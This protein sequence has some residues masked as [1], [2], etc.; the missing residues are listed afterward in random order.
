LWIAGALGYVMKSVDLIPDGIEDLGYLDDALV[1][2][3]A[4]DRAVKEAGGDDWDIPPQLTRLADDTKVIQQI[5]GSDYVRLDEYV[6]G[7]RILVVRGRSPSDIVQDPSLAL[8]VSQDVASLARAYV[9][10]P[11]AQ[12]GRTLIKLTSFLQAKLP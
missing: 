8:Q 9:P 6:S 3:V 7:L 1:L 11:L 5:L 4:C 10:A 12:D 2:R